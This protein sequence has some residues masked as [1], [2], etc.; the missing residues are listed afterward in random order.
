MKRFWDKVEKTDGCWNWKANKANGYGHF[1][2]YGKKIKAHRYSWIM[3]YGEIPAGMLICHHCDNKACVNPDH[4]FIGTQSDNLKDCVRKGRKPKLF[5]P[6]HKYRFKPG[7]KPS[8]RHLNDFDAWI[9][10]YAYKVIGLRPIQIYK[11]TGVSYR[12]I[13]NIIHEHC[14]YNVKL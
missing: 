8:T 4:L 6:G 11:I 2:L 3:K 12:T 13:Q 7:Y 5:K 1:S 14:Y 10:K 9:I